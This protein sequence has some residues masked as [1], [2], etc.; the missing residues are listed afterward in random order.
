MSEV[1]AFSAL[2]KLIHS[3]PEYA[4]AWHCNLAVPIID[5]GA[6]QRQANEAAALI[7]AQMFD[8]DITAHPNYQWEKSGAQ[9]YFE[10]RR[11]A[12]SHDGTTRKTPEPS[13]GGA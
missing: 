9:A 2:Q 3:D 1:H 12:D 10:A 13:S 6:S 11:E 7:M 4:W 8:Y 5:A